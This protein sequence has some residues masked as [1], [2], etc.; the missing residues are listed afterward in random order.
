MTKIKFNKG[1][2][3]IS[4]CD[5]KKLIGFINTKEFMKYI[6]DPTLDVKEFVKE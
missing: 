2:K 1:N 4:I 3:V 6:N 5:G